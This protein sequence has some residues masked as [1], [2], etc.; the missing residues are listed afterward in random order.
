MKLIIIHSHSEVEEK[1]PLK[2][3]G[4]HPSLA[5]RLAELGVIEIEDGCITPAHLRRAFRVLR[6]WNSLKVNLTGASIVVELLE[7]MEEMQEEIK[8]L[9]REVSRDGF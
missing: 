3:S 7:K 9:R 8:R 5:K 1:L 4:L 6:L 2:H